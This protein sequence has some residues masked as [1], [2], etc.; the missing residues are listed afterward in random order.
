VFAAAAAA[1]GG[2]GHGTAGGG[3]RKAY[4]LGGFVDGPVGAPQLAIVHGGERVLTPEQQ[5]AGG[6]GDSYVPIQVTLTLDG[7]VVGSA[8]HEAL[9]R[10]QR[11]GGTLRFH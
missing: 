7:R 8:L 10:K 1:A 9:L 6:G 2:P 5:A 11:Q 4:A 3:T